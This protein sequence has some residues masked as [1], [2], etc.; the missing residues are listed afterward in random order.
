MGVDPTGKRWAVQINEA[1]APG[2]ANVASAIALGADGRPHLLRQGRLNPP[3]REEQPVL[4]A[5]FKRLTGLTPANIANGSTKIKR[6]WYVVT[7]LD[8]SNEEIRLNTARF[9]DACVIARS[10]G[11]GGGSPADLAISAELTAADES[12]GTYFVGAKAARDATVVRKWQGEVWTSLAKFLRAKDFI[13]SK[14]RP[15]GRYEVDAEV[16]RENLRLLF[17]IK[18]GSAAADIYSGLGQLLIYAKL[19]PRLVSY[20]PVLLLP[21]CPPNLS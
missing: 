7:A 16:V 21:L 19:M 13:V 8:V 1:D 20:Q 3:T 2:D 14:P 5:E 6:D 17:E 12:G 10:K 9:V 18:T 11:E 4:F 15:A